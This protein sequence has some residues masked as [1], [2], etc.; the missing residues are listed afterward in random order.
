M[1][2]ANYFPIIYKRNSFVARI[3]TNATGI[4]LWNVPSGDYVLLPI[5]D[6]DPKTAIQ[7]HGY[8]SL[9]ITDNIPVEEGFFARKRDFGYFSEE[10]I[11][12]L[13]KIWYDIN[14]GKIQYLFSR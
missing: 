9:R 14:D 11:R 7:I 2:C 1:N 5:F 4:P 10:E 6:K 3:D 12:D 13:N 8:Y